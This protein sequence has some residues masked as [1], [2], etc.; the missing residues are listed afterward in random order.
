MDL[1]WNIFDAVNRP[2]LHDQWIP[3]FL[4]IEKGFKLFYNSFQPPFSS[5]I[6]SFL[7]ETGYPS[8]WKDDFKDYYGYNVTAAESFGVVQ[9]IARQ[10]GL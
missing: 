7:L 10:D 9:S 1:E 4:E 3:Y 8:S 2:R 6:F 5:L